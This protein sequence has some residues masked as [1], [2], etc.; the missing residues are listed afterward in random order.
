ML[1][2]SKIIARTAEEEEWQTPE[3]SAASIYRK[4]RMEKKV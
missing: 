4:V 3:W 2:L 1:E